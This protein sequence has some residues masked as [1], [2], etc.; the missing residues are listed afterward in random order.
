MPCS[1]RL[2]PIRANSLD[3][4][5]RNLQ[6]IV[7]YEFIKNQPIHPLKERKNDLFCEVTTKRLTER[8][9]DLTQKHS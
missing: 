7:Y 8:D 3:K 6:A 2:P 1:Q 9:L 4:T 5:F